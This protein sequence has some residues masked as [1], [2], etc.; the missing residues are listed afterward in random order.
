MYYTFDKK[1]YWDVI[2]LIIKEH[3]R[4]AQFDFL[5]IYKKLFKFYKIQEIDT[6][7]RRKFC[8][9][10]QKLILSIYNFHS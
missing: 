7:Q 5:N 3:E 8:Y 1:S 4:E 9:T 6:D 10:L 2:Y